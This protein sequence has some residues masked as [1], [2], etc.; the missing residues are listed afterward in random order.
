M[1]VIAF[2]N[3]NVYYINDATITDK[4]A[5]VKVI[6]CKNLSDLMK[7]KPGAYRYFAIGGSGK[8]SPEEF[9][10]FVEQKLAPQAQGSEIMDDVLLFGPSAVVQRFRR[11]ALKKNRQ[12][13]K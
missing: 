8:I 13:G 1:T 3:P 12:R 5:H 9:G 10:D 11:A 2:N 6:H 4:D 7:V